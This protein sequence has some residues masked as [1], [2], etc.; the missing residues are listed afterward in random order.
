M[1]NSHLEQMVAEWYE[2]QGY[3]IRRNVL[4]GRRDRGG[5]ESELA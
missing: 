3:F 1:A 5:F 4:V 2:Y